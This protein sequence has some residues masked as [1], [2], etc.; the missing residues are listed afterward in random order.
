M[1]KGRLCGSV[2]MLCCAFDKPEI[3]IVNAFN[4]KMERILRNDL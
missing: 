4:L 2:S 3:V 1:R